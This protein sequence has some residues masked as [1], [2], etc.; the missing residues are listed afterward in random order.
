MNPDTK[1]S[2]SIRTPRRPVQSGHQ[3]VPFNP[4]GYGVPFNPDGK[5]PDP[6]QKRTQEATAVDLSQEGSPLQGAGCRKTDIPRGATNK[7]FEDLEEHLS[8]QPSDDKRHPQDSVTPSEK[9][10]P[11]EEVDEPPL[12]EE[13]EPPAPPAPED[14]QLLAEVREVLD[15]DSGR[16]IRSF[17]ESVRAK[18]DGP[19]YTAERVAGY[20]AD[21]EDLPYAG[22]KADLVP[23]VRYI[24]WEW[25]NER[26]AAVA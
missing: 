11:K 18:Y 7:D 21:D 4:D 16:W 8:S 2:R 5:A 20:L 14:T 1:A 12:V 13:T 10:A 9:T 26:K 22:Q 15:P 24:F 23:C 17:A 3:G 25:A 6:I 19:G